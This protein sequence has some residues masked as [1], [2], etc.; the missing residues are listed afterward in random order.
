MP[1]FP[2]TYEVYFDETVPWILELTRYLGAWL[3]Q[4]SLRLPARLSALHDR[5]DRGG[6]AVGE[7]G[8]RD[9]DLTSRFGE[10]VPF[11][12]AMALRR[13]ADDLV[14]HFS[15]LRCDVLRQDAFR[16]PPGLSLEPIWW[17]P[18][19]RI[20][21]VT[22]IADLLPYEEF[23]DLVVDAGYTKLAFHQDWDIRWVLAW[24]GAFAEGRALGLAD[25]VVAPM[26]IRAVRHFGA[27]LRAARRLMADGFLRDFRQAL[28]SAS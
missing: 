24:L 3:E 21:G 18:N 2:P 6:V 17:R 19:V 11:L 15:E 4:A 12:E 1:F 14:A 9:A 16:V 20:S 7:L 27:A 26:K 8:E 10:E 25:D 5:L 22:G 13:P 23:C 28:P